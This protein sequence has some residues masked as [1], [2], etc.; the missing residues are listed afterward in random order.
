[1]RNGLPAAS[2]CPLADTTPCHPARGSV[3][4][5]QG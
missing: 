3:P 2:P 1:M 4:R 5:G